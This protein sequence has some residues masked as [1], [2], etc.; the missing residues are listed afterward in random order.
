MSV[1]GQNR[2]WPRLNR[3]SVL[4]SR[5]DIVRTTPAR[6]FRAMSGSPTFTCRLVGMP[7]GTSFG[8]PS[9]LQSLLV[10]RQVFSTS[11]RAKNVFEFRNTQRGFSRQL[12][13]LST[14]GPIEQP[15]TIVAGDENVY[16]MHIMAPTRQRLENNH[17]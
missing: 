11:I 3:M 17:L 16:W 7:V 15:R 2:K 10:S 9:F 5:A 12:T 13:V 14:I 6:P 4:P 1:V 8:Q